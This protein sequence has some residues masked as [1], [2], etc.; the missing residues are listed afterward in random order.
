MIS[1][2]KCKETEKLFKQRK[3][4]KFPP[5]IARRALRKLMYLDAAKSLDDLRI[6]PAN[7][8]EALSGNRK[9]Q[10]SIRV[11][12]QFRICFRWEEGSIHDVEIIDYH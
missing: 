4:K 2:Y 5:E 12:K 1:S 11:N 10:H 9:G 3:A 6:P 7:H 8:L